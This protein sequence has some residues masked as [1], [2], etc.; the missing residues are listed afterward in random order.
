MIG[1]GK[2]FLI[3]FPDVAKSN[4]SNDWLITLFLQVKQFTLFYFQQKPKADI[5]SNTQL[6]I[7][8][9]SLCGFLG[10]FS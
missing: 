1:L 3:H 2:A 9:R 8:G 6:K 4:V 10:N 7:N 5:S